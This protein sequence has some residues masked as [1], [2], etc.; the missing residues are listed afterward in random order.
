MAKKWH[1]VQQMTIPVLPILGVVAG[2][3]EAIDAVMH[4]NYGFAIDSLKY[5]YLGL[6]A[7]GSFHLDAL[8]SGWLPIALGVIGHYLMNRFGVNRMFARMKVP[9]FRL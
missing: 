5:H 7:D 4:G 9:L 2:S 8:A 6:W 3:T 1:R